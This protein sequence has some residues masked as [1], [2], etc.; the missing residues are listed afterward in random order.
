MTLR[1]YNTLTRRVE[2]FVPLAPGRVT[3]YTCGPTVYN[4][5]H[6]GNFR[7]FLFEDLLRRWLEASG[8]DVFH[9]MNI[10]DVDDKTIKGATEAGQPLRAY[11]QRYIEAFHEDRRYLRIRDASVYPRAT[12]YIPAMITLVERLLEKGVAYRGEDGS[13]YFAIARFPAYGRLSQL[14]RRELK[15]GASERVSADEYAKEDVRDFALWKAARPEDEAVGA[16]W[17]APFGR[18]RPGWH[19]ECSAMALELVRAHWGG[20][21]L[22]IHA[23]GVDLIFPHHEDEIAQS[24]AYTGQELFARYWVHG[25]FLNIRGEKMSKRFGNITTARDLR[26]DG[27]DA[28]A[29]RLLMCQVHYRQRL[30]LTDEALASAREGS[31][32]LGEFQNRMRASRAETDAPAF[33]E[34]AARL[35]LELAEAL[36]DDLNAPRAVAALF[37]FASTGNAALDQGAR[38][39]SRAV[40]AWERAEGVLGVTSAVEVLTVGPALEFGAQDQAELAD[41][42]PDGTE[43]AARTWAVRWAV[44]RKDAKAA[45]DFAEADRI[46]ARLKEAGWEVRDGRD[47]SMEVRRL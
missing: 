45:R 2:P 25:E 37:A 9:V 10:T 20:E 19:L 43:D 46:R 27:V 15:A 14:D 29:I 3:L 8:Y 36:D 6:I 41:T 31:R 16:A 11:V 4:Y 24:C 18:G 32:R 40:A 44:R 17:D 42:P 26:Q 23:G 13:V 28:G 12:D 30:D 39:G 1:L 21:V 33:A 22:D 38:P 47:G 5:A 35:E 7:T 34:A